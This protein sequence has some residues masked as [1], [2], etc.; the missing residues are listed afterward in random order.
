MAV[1]A[2][3]GV[4]LAI[5]KL[6]SKRAAG[7]VGSRLILF[8][9]ITATAAASSGGF[10]NNLCMRMVELEKGIELQ[11]PDTGE[12]LGKSKLCAKSAVMQ[13]ASSRI[14]LALPISIPAMMLVG[15]E[16]F[17]AVPRNK[18][19]ALALQITLIAL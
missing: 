1:T 13:T 17:G 10:V 2:S 8:N 6:L 12:N 9:A 4:S 7:A 11:D 16:R 3:I 14:L 19:L 18:H 15:L 5:R